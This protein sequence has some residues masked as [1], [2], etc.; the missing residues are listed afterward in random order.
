MIPEAGGDGLYWRVVVN[1]CGILVYS[2]N[3]AAGFHADQS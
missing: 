1:R 2:E 3:P